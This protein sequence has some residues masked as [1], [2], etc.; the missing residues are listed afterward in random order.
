VTVKNV[1]PSDAQNVTLADTLPSALD[2]TNA[3]VCLGGS[4]TPTAAYVNGSAFPASSQPTLAP[5]GTLT[6][7]FQAPVKTALRDRP[8][9]TNSVTAASPTADP[10]TDSDNR[11]NSRSDDITTVPDA[12][13]LIAAEP[14]NASI[15]VQWHPG[16]NGTPNNDSGT[17][18]S[19]ITDWV[20]L[21]RSGATTNVY[22]RTLSQVTTNTA[23]GDVSVI[24]P[25]GG[26]ALTNNTNYN[27]TVAAR[28]AA[29]D[30]TES[31]Q[32]SAKPCLTCGVTLVP[33]GGATTLYAFN[34]TITNGDCFPKSNI[35]TA[36]GATSADPIVS[37]L[38]LT[39]LGAKAGFVT[40]VREQSTVSGDCGG[41]ACIGGQVSLSIP[42]GTGSS[43][44]AEQAVVFDKTITTGLK[45]SDICNS[46]PCPGSKKVY[47]VFM[48]GTWIGSS[49]MTTWCSASTPAGQP[50]VISYVHVNTSENPS[51]I[52]GNTPNGK[53]GNGDLMLRVRIYA[54]PSLGTCRTCR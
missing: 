53:N 45:N 19:P 3:T 26:P 54:D 24:V 4:C 11:S 52:N 31:N 35:E 14:G 25:G 41:T 29:G 20:I 40:A 42:P 51:K 7:T 18:G 27:V 17:G 10:G 36:P 34:T 12:P 49:L 30:S 9:A 37:C 5:N 16:D 8:N 28:N 50:C 46:T 6:V 22:A 33:S 39:N 43:T 48:N 1:G 13:T 15:A 47:D 38:K 44:A 2:A 23:T 32:K 21:V